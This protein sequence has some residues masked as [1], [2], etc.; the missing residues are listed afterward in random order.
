MTGTAK[1]RVTRPATG[2]SRRAVLRAV[3]AGLGSALLLTA[4]GDG[5][6]RPLYG[7]ASL[8]GANVTEKLAQVEFAPIP[9]RVGQRIRNELIFQATGGGTAPPAMYRM[10]I[11]VANSVTSTLV[12]S[13]GNSLSSIVA[14]DASFRLVR[15]S[16]RKVVLEGKSYGR[17]SYERFQSIFANVSAQEDAE[18]RAAR[19]IGEE[20]R[21][22]LSAYL[23]TST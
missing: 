2:H 13:D 15:I 7:S 16:D 22:R 5:G 20:L 23:S 14:L 18:N 21:T 4:C 11:A 19:T 10:E 9:G 8:G 12:K 1:Q 17:A 3:A 6:F